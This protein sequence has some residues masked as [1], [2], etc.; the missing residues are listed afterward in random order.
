[1]NTAFPCRMETCNEG[2]SAASA[3]CDR[4]LFSGQRRTLP[5]ARDWRVRRSS[6]SGMPVRE[7]IS[8][9]ESVSV[10]LNS[11]STHAWCTL[12]C[13]PA[14]MHAYAFDGGYKGA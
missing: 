1:M 4:F 13:M 9:N 5:S 6:G 11:S 10:L 14:H 8:E 12:T 3:H 7:E 2:S